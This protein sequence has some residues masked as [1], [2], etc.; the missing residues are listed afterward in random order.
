MDDTLL[1]RWDI[2][3]EEL[4]EVVDQNPSLRG[5][6]FGYVAEVKLRQ[7][8]ASDDRVSGLAKDDDHDRAK[9][10]DLRFMYGG[11]EFVLETKSLQTNS[12]KVE[13]TLD[14]ERLTGKAQCDASDRREVLFP[15]GSKLATT[16]LRVGE[17]DVLAINIYTFFGEWK[18]IFAAN[19]NLPRSRY[20]KYTPEQRKNLLASLVPV[21]WPLAEN[22]IFTTD[23][24]VLL[25]RLLQEQ[26][27]R[28]IGPKLLED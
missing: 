21:E 1:D 24:F 14:G 20:K 22:S 7:Y 27:V 12:I 4:T 3:A 9:K 8:I 17:F 16:C 23:L 5:M 6:L 26:D 25:D 19:L 11:R 28:N 10:G 18:F 2:T 15:D 13:K